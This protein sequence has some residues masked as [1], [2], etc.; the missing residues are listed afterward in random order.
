MEP[1]YICRDTSPRQEHLLND[2]VDGTHS[3][4]YESCPTCGVMKLQKTPENI[5]FFYSQGYYSFS[6]QGPLLSYLKSLRC[7]YYLKKPTLINR[8]LAKKFGPPPVVRW[9]EPIPVRPGARLLDVGCGQGIALRDLSRAGFSRLVGVDP[10]LSASVKYGPVQLIKSQ[11][12]DIH[13]SFDIV[14]LSHSLEHMH[15]PRAILQQVRARLNPLGH[16]ILRVPVFG[17]SWRH[18]GKHWIDLDAPRHNFIFTPKSVA[19]LAEQV[20]LTLEK[21]VYDMEG[22][23]LWASEQLAQGILPNSPRS[24]AVNPEKSIF[25]AADMQRFDR[26]AC[27][28]N[29]AGEA[30]QASFYLKPITFSS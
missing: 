7:A 27:E 3:F 5:D 25:S 20:G 9:L 29:A 17:Y 19:M 21:T 11:L 30:D 16:V 28:L 6:Q 14:I 15:D 26:L 8:L 22:F 1:C 12:A 13:E 24:H 18:Y 4:R 10:Y 23:N 2:T